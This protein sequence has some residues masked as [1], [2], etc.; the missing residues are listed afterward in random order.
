[1]ATHTDDYIPELRGICCEALDVRSVIE[2][3]IDPL[4]SLCRKHW[5]QDQDADY[6]D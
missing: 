2:R 3:N 1:M 4:I 6:H 5:G